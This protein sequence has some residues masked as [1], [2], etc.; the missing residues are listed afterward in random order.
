MGLARP[1]AEA[2][3]SAIQ[4]EYTSTYLVLSDLAEQLRPETPARAPGCAR[5]SPG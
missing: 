4:A 3:A 1:A 5:R 2:K